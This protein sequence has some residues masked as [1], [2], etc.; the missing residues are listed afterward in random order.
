MIVN[1]SVKKLYNI[2]PGYLLPFTNS[3]NF[4]NKEKVS[5][6]KMSCWRPGLAPLNAGA[7]GRKEKLMNEQF[8]VKNNHDPV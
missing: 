6:D 1:Y 7:E 8:V 4:F 3:A 5:V 2:T